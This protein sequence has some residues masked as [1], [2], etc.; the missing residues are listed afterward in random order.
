MRNWPGIWGKNN[1]ETN[2]L[3]MTDCSKNITIALAW[4]LAWGDKSIP[5]YD[6]SILGAMYQGFPEK[7]TDLRDQYPHLWEETTPIGLVYGGAT[8]IKKNGYMLRFS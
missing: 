5:R 4:C 8:K 2:G 3:F 1:I 7:I 6:L